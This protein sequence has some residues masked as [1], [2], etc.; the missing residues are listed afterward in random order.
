MR[1]TPGQEAD[2]GQAL[3]LLEGVDCQAVV[4]DKAYD[5]NAIVDHFTHQEIA[6]V[7]PPK[8]NQFDQRLKDN[9]EEDESM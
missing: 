9:T 3:A 4:A 2:S 8:S 5:T 7:I 1:L 6:V